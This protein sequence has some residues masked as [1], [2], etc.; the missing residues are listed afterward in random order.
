[1]YILNILFSLG[2][3]D[4]TCIDFLY[5]FLPLKLNKVW[6]ILTA[7]LYTILLLLFFCT[8]L[9]SHQGRCIASVMEFS[10]PKSPG[11]LSRTTIVCSFCHSCCYLLFYTFSITFP[12]A[13]F[14]LLLLTDEIFYAHC[15]AVG[16]FIEVY[17][18]AL[19]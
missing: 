2:N 18:R 17:R 12:S 1:M 11:T 7:P 14:L 3:S 16:V 5:I 4:S 13:L 15:R 9:Q 8:F 10:N 19:L 6:G